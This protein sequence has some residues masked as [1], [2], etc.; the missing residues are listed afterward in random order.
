[1]IWDEDFGPKICTFFVFEGGGKENGDWS[2][3]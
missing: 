3:D 2:M 1:M